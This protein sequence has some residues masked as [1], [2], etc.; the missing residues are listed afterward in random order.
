MKLPHDVSDKALAQKLI[1]KK[2]N[3]V[4]L[5][6][7]QNNWTI[8]PQAALVT[9]WAPSIPAPGIPV[10]AMICNNCGNLRLHALGPLDMLPK[11]EG[12]SNG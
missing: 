7:G 9:Q 1:E 12:Q 4:C 11:Q 5:S 6:C 2:A 3:P 10:A 8:L